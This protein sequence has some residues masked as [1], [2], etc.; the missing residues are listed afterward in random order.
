MNSFR[1]KIRDWL[2]R[3]LA[4]KDIVVINLK[5]VDG[6][7]DVG[8]KYMLVVGTKLRILP[9]MYERMKQRQAEKAPK[10]RSKTLE[11]GETVW[12]DEAH[13]ISKDEY[14]IGNTMGAHSDPIFTHQ[15]K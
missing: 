13:Y 8:D 3:R 12:L 6:Y 9:T 15:E 14:F 1:L 4:G 10:F 2:L 5:C 11:L 7:I